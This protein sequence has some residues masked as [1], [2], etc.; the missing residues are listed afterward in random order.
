[1]LF[2][3]LPLFIFIVL[4][5]T[6]ITIGAGVFAY[7]TFISENKAT[8]EM[9][10]FVF[11][12]AALVLCIC[13]LSIVFYSRQKRS[14]LQ[15]INKLVRV[16]SG[17]ALKRFGEFGKLGKFLQSFFENILDISEK[18]ANRI[19]FLDHALRLACSTSSEPFLIVNDSGFIKYVSK[20][21]ESNGFEKNV[22]EKNPAGS[23]GNHSGSAK[24]NITGAQ[25][26]D[27]YPDVHYDDIF[28]DISYSRSER[29]E[30]GEKYTFHFFPIS[31]RKNEVN[32]LFV[33]IE[34]NTIISAG[35]ETVKQ[36]Y[37]NIIGHE[38]SENTSPG[39]T[40]KPKKSIL[41]FLK[42]DKKNSKNSSKP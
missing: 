26:S 15:R 28:T 33:G 18:R 37:E 31:E 32:G 36:I 13:F 34:K 2:I 5:S 1:M 39:K 14:A 6:G 11:L 12:C 23:A 9:L 3:S 27:L 41:S 17:A 24:K 22:T 40:A 38:K 35:S 8:A 20:G 10:L 16:N 29:T 7:R 21:F 25:F 30:K 4:S 19:V 42:N